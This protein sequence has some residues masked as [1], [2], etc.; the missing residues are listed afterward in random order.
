ML[1]TKAV[2][3]AVFGHVADLGETSAPASKGKARERLA[4]LIPL[5][6]GRSAV[7]LCAIAA[8]YAP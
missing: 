6:G 7:T 8:T 1:G 3:F 2:N 4:R 5:R